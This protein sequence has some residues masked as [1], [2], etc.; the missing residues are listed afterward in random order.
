MPLIS[1]SARHQLVLRDQGYRA[2]ASRGVPDLSGWLHTNMD[3]FAH[4]KMVTHP[5]TNQGRPGVT[6]LIESN[7]LALSQTANN[8]NN[9][10]T[11]Q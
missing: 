2:S 9:P 7:A 5:N 1:V 8:S 6:S 4:P 10:N 11:E 3:W